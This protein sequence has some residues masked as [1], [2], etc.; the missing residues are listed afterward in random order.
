MPTFM[1]PNN[2][3]SDPTQ[4]TH[5]QSRTDKQMEKDALAAGRAPPAFTRVPSK[6]QP[7]RVIDDFFNSNGGG[8]VGVGG[9]GVGISVGSILIGNR[10]LPQPLPLQSLANSNANAN[11]K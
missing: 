10:P 5:N 6:R 2:R 11:A 3:M 8:G 9:G 1:L 7:R 4:P